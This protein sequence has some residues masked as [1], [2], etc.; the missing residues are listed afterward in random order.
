MSPVWRGF[1]GLF[2]V[3][4]LAIY[5]TEMEDRTESEKTLVREVGP[6]EAASKAFESDNVAFYEV[7]FS[8]T[9]EDGR[10]VGYWILHGEKEIPGELLDAYP[11]RSQ[12]S[13]S[14]YFGLTHE[15]NSFTRRARIWSLAYNRHL[16][17]LLVAGGSP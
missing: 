17:K 15:Q 2:A 16:A 9:D 3:V 4:F 13:Y 7:W 10:E 11:D 1:A 8:L 12:F 5:V 14:K 6:I